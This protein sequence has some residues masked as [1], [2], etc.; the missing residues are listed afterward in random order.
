MKWAR[1]FQPAACS[2]VEELSI[3]T[4]VDI[5]KLLSQQNPKTI[6]SNNLIE[7]QKSISPINI[8]F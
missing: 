5:S 6:T 2:A 4:D 1:S 3:K 7:T 8:Y